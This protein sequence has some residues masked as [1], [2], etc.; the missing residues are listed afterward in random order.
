[1]H[2]RDKGQDIYRVYSW[3]YQKNKRVKDIILMGCDGLVV[4]TGGG[5][6]EFGNSAYYKWADQY[7]EI[8]KQVSS[9]ARLATQ[10]D[11]KT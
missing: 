3:T 7:Q 10:A 2:L 5:V 9:V 8:M 6:K 4:N 11:F 1:M